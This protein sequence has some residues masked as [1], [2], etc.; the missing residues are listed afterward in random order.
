M[1]LGL[2]DVEQVIASGEAE[3]DENVSEGRVARARKR[4]SNRGALPVHLLR[5]EI[6]VDIDDKTCPCCNGELQ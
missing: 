2:E 4:R 6:T 1:L 3:Q 5:V